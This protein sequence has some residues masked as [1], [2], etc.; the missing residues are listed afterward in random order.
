[1]DFKEVK[2]HKISNI[3]SFAILFAFTVVAISI[4]IISVVLSATQNAGA[5]KNPEIIRAKVLG[6]RMAVSPTPVME[7]IAVKPDLAMA[8]NYFM[9]Y[10]NGFGDELLYFEV[11]DLNKTGNVSPRPSVTVSLGLK[12]VDLTA[13]GGLYQ[14]GPRYNAT[15]NLFLK[16]LPV[17]R[18]A[19]NSLKFTIDKNNI[20]SET[21]EANNSYTLNIY[22][23]LTP[24]FFRRGDFN[25]DGKIDITDTMLFGKILSSSVKR[26]CEDAIDVNDDGK[27]D[28]SDQVY[29]NNWQYIGGPAP[30]NPGPK[31]PQ[32]DPTPDKLGCAKYPKE[33]TPIKAP[34]LHVSLATSTPKIVI[35]GE[36]NVEMA[37]IILD[38]TKSGSN[39]RVSSI[40]VDYKTKDLSP[41]ALQGIQL[42]I[43]SKELYPISYERICSGATCSSLNTHARVIFS[44]AVGD[45]RIDKGTS[46]TVRIIGDISTLY[47]SGSFNIYMSGDNVQAYDDEARS[48]IPTYTIGETEPISIVSGGT[49]QVSIASDPKPA[50]VIGNTTTNIGKFQAKSMHEAVELKSFGFSLMP[51]D[52]GISGDQD[53]ID[54]LELWEEGGITALGSVTVN[55]NNATITPQLIKPVASSTPKIFIVKARWTNFSA[56]TQAKSGAGLRVKLSFI[57]AVGISSG[58]STQS[59]SLFIS[60]LGQSFNSFHVLKS[61]PYVKI[62]STSDR[63]TGN[64]TQLDLFKFNIKADPAG[65]IGTAKFTFSVST[66]TISLDPSGYYLFHSTSNNVLGDLLSYSN[67]FRILYGSATNSPTILEAR[68]DVNNDDSTGH[69]KPGLTENLL[70]SAGTTRYFTLQGTTRRGHTVMGGDEAIAVSLAGDSSFASTRLVNVANIDGAIDQDDFIWSDLNFDQYSS[71]TATQTVGWFNGYRVYGLEDTTSTPQIIT[72]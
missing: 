64:F 43:G 7:S 32:V 17:K 22:I 42:F 61:L 37:Q 49:I 65:P 41:E 21:N 3:V 44:I 53:E 28:I 68:F 35:S 4:F 66:T 5:L 31:T 63:I 15:F 2:K 11:N 59:G 58:S 69:N 57:D 45:M 72:D 36:Q 29:Y 62:S 60:G 50:L 27:V 12:S 39:I 20:L 24:T 9:Y 13:I 51:P 54:V 56:N 33:S 19:I 47:T 30:K 40:R 48:V 67:D 52:G 55:S 10:I 25:A 71:S 6:V 23:D 16:N 34:G 8:A 18:G 46:K 26:P 70:I 14:N 38:A 1:M